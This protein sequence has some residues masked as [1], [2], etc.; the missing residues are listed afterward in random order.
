MNGGIYDWRGV[1]ELLGWETYN[2]I[3][4]AHCNSIAQIPFSLERNNHYLNDP[5][6]TYGMGFPCVRTVHQ[7]V[8]DLFKE[9]RLG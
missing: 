8:R 2:A 9:I 1:T 6:P 3:A 7:L 5:P 4:L